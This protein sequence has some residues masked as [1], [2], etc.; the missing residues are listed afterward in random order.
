MLAAVRSL[1]LSYSS[2]SM[3]IILVFS[4]SSP[5]IQSL[6]EI[7]IPPNSVNVSSGETTS[8]T[9]LQPK[10][11]SQRFVKISWNSPSTIRV[12]IR[13]ILTK[14]KSTGYLDENFLVYCGKD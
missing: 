13:T 11:F 12:W 7:T 9:F 3:L 4:F 1:I 2:T 5:P 8:L 14:E 10:G 6:M